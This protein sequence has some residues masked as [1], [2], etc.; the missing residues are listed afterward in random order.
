MRYRF[1]IG[2]QLVVFFILMQIMAVSCGDDHNQVK[3]QSEK[4][5]TIPEKASWIQEVRSNE[6]RPDGRVSHY[7]NGE[8]IGLFGETCDHS[9][10]EIRSKR[11]GAIAIGFDGTVYR[12]RSVEN[13]IWFTQENIEAGIHINT[14]AIVDFISAKNLMDPPELIFHYSRNL[15][16][17]GGSHI[18]ALDP[19]ADQ[20]LLFNIGEAYPGMRYNWQEI[21]NKI[22]E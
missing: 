4:A 14:I 18:S 10:K 21:S 16:S 6:L 1:N 9:G 19:D 11:Y 12:F 8:G 15:P 2:L 17:P 13:L 20:S 5:Q 3:N 7:Y 22:T